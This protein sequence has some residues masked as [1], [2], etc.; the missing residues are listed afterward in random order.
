MSVATIVSY[1]LAASGLLVMV[2]SL[3]RLQMHRVT[4]AAANRFISKQLV[5]KS[6]DRARKICSAA[7]GTYLDAVRAA[8]VAVPES[9]DRVTIDAAIHG[10]FEPAAKQVEQQWHRRSEQGLL[11]AILVAGGLALQLSGGGTHVGLWIAAGI[12]ALGAIG[13]LALRRHITVA[14]ASARSELLPQLLEAAAGGVLRTA[15]P[16]P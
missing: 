12:A 16:A 9:K 3:L 6:L 15:E 8:I 2:V 10:A 1:A 5:E 7:P 13:L 14:L 11:G 4:I